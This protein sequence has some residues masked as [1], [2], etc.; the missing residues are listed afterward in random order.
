VQASIGGNPAA[1]AQSLAASG[2]GGDTKIIATGLDKIVLLLRHGNSCLRT[3][4]ED[5]AVSGFVDLF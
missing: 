4:V 3:G 1:F 2:V 5:F